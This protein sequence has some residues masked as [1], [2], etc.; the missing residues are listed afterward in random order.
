VFYIATSYIEK[1]TRGKRTDW[2]EVYDSNTLKLKSEIPIANTRA[3][4]LNYRP[5]FQGSADNR[6]LLI[7]N[8]TPATSVSVVDLNAQKQ[9]AEIPNPGCYGTFPAAG[10]ALR[11]ATMCGDGTFGSYMLSA[12]GSAAERTASEKIFD[13]DSDALFI[14]GERDGNSWIFASFTGNLYVVDLEGQTA[15]LVEKIEMTKGI[16]GDWRP[17]GYQ[18][19]AFHAKSGVLFV[20]MHKGGA[21]GSHKNPAEEIWAYDVSNKKLLAR[22]PTST[23]FSIGVGQGDDPVVYAIDLVNLKVLRYTA[24]ASKDYA[25]TLAGEQKAGST[26]IQIET[27]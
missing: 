15:K 18:T 2:L 20:L 4:A 1:I 8:A 9:T 24:D 27:Q 6:W 17:S 23:A 3:Q 16:E 22:S 19:H 14:H 10:N 26:P 11:F 25:L 13:A 5:L 7:Q 21:E 12:D